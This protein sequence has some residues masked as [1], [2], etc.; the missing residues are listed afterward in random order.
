MTAAAET[1][2]C[3]VPACTR[4]IPVHR[5]MCRPHWYQ[6]PKPLR[7][8]IWATWRSGAGVFDPQYRDAVRR[9][10][11]AA[12]ARPPG[13]RGLGARTAGRRRHRA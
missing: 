11:A 3:T 2:K 7:D 8:L 10:I 12:G 13:K 9:A 1:H 6:V 5:L 4:Q